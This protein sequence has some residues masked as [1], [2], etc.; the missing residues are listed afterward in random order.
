MTCTRRACQSVYRS[1]GAMTDIIF[2]AHTR[3]IHAIELATDLEGL[4]GCQL[5]I[6]LN[7]A[8]LVIP[9]AELTMSPLVVHLCDAGCDALYRTSQFPSCGQ[10]QSRLVSLFGE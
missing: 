6:A 5:K 4:I 10:C 2:G 9:T 3:E 7:N 1:L 8:A